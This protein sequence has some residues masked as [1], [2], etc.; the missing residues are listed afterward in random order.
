LSP[1]EGPGACIKCHAVTR[2]AEDGP[3]RIEWRYHKDEARS[4][5]SYS[6]RRHLRLVDPQGVKLADPNKGCTTCHGLD[7]NADFEAGFK[8]YDPATYSSNFVSMKKKTCVQCHAQGRVR[9]DCQ[10]CHNYH[11]EPAFTKR[12]TRNEN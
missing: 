4:Y 1:K 7:A 5:Q 3:L 2:D 11:K 6:H 9:Q 12:V 10:L 8:D